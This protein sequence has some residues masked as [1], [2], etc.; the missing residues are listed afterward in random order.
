MKPNFK[1]LL[2]PFILLIVLSI[3]MCG[4][5]KDDPAND[6]DG[7]GDGYSG[8]L[9]GGGKS[10]EEPDTPKDEGDSD[11]VYHISTVDELL[12]MK[13]KGKY[14]L[15]NDIDM[16][17]KK[18]T[19]IGSYEAPFYGSFDG[20]G[21]KIIG[22]YV[23]DASEDIGIM[24]T[25]KYSYCGLFGYANGAQI[26]DLT[27]ENA[28]IDI[29]ET[30]QNRNIYAGILGGYFSEC[31]LTNVTVSGSV[32]VVSSN[33]SGYAGGIAGGIA[34]T[35]AS[36]CVSLASVKTDNCPERAESGGLF[37]VAKDNSSV[38]NS[39]ATGDVYA[40]TTV[41]IAYSGGLFGYCF[42]TSVT[43]SYSSSKVYSEVSSSASKDGKKGAA[44]S[45][46]LA[47]I[48][49]SIPTEKENEDPINNCVFLRSYYVG[50]EIT[51][52]GG[53][54]AAYIAGLVCKS[55][56]T[57]FTH[58]YSSTVIKASGNSDSV[59]AAGI[60]TEITQYTKING[61]FFLGNAEL[62]AKTSSGAKFGTLY[63][64]VANGEAKNIKLSAYS[65]SN[66][67]TINGTTYKCVTENAKKI[68]INGESRISGTFY[69][70]TKLSSD[71]G[72]NTD[73]WQFTEGSLP[74]HAQ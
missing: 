52:N 21:H 6:D 59:S 30:A 29:S 63:L 47:A 1:R 13:R 27:L 16:T 58:C 43:D 3:V 12:S 38:S 22:L 60:S 44:Y 5:A 42:T 65:S 73:E 24:A 15:D 62:K 56:Y 68:T 35:S 40:S 45:G 54:S 74:K 14:V 25:F 55:D 46:G 49:S 57:T 71:L 48:A 20:N 70:P 10:D 8:S 31:T 61:C 67:C 66:S 4:C 18:W 9:S 19:P 17:D 23:S 37:A 72:W 53:E 69:D 41:G 26:K 2:L 7:P 51:A 64:R 28:Q 11:T 36:R 34:K 50:S 33:Y 39:Y 32:S